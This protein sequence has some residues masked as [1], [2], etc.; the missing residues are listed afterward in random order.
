MH[1][2]GNCSAL[3]VLRQSGYQYEH[4]SR[5]AMRA[6]KQCKRFQ[7]NLSL[8]RESLCWLLFPQAGSTCAP[9]ESMSEDAPSSKHFGDERIGPD[10]SITRLEA[11]RHHE[12]RQHLNRSAH[13]PLQSKAHSTSTTTWTRSDSNAPS[14]LMNDTEYGSNAFC[15]T[16]ACA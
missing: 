13:N 5:P 15:T 16:K 11:A 1:C 6:R 7:K 2:T 4:S 3:A 10:V 14:L 9:P 12:H 8:L